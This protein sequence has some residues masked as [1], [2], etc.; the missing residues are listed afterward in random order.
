MVDATAAVEAVADAAF[1][2]EVAPAVDEGTAVATAD[3]AFPTAAAVVDEAVVEVVVV[4]VDEALVM[5]WQPCQ[6]PL[7]LHPSK[8]TLLKPVTDMQ[9]PSRPGFGTAGRRV[10][11]WANHF[12]VL[13]QNQGD[14][15]HY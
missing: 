12:A 3:V 2:M 4:M 13:K 11:L 5:P 9:F 8:S 15:Y 10:T 1:P 14:V 7:L 6:Q